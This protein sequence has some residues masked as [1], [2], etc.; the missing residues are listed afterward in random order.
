MSSNKRVDVPHQSDIL[1]GRT[2]ESIKHVGNVTFRTLVAISLAAYCALPKHS[3]ED[4]H[5][6]IASIFES[7][8]E[9]KGRFLLKNNDGE[10]GWVEVSDEKAR[11]KIRQ[12]YHNSLKKPH[13]VEAFTVDT[14]VILPF[15]RK[16]PDFDWMAM[17]EACDHYLHPRVLAV[18][19][20]AVLPTERG[21]GIETTNFEKGIEDDFD[22]LMGNIFGDL[23]ATSFDE[24]EEPFVFSQIE[25]RASAPHIDMD[26]EVDM[27]KAPGTNTN[28]CAITEAWEQ[29]LQS[30]GLDVS[31]KV[32]VPAE[33]GKEDEA[34][35]YSEKG[36][37]A[38]VDTHMGYVFEGH[39]A[40]SFFEDQ[41]RFKFRH[42][43]EGTALAP[44]TDVDKEVDMVKAPSRKT[45]FSATTKV[46]AQG[47]H[48]LMLDVSNNEKEGEALNNSEMSIEIIFDDSVSEGVASTDSD[49]SSTISSLSSM[50][51]EII[52][53][54]HRNHFR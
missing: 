44:R 50:S 11:E 36:L 41:E 52:F 33:N 15:F 46:C 28:F 43:I 9:G 8:K 29:G 40:T 42:G 45:N 48:S 16:P 2:D 17:V 49:I 21:K 22:T 23:N 38:D 13:I 10:G 39:H 53:D 32:V 27:V 20:N 4:K 6:F 34:V 1:F 12:Q 31:N 14:L 18:S 26:K 51:I 24:N 19:N 37:N 35:Y 7:I 5:G 47:V 25:G 54:E 30:V 3:R